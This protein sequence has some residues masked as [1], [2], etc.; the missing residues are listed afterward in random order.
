MHNCIYVIQHYDSVMVLRFAI[1][2]TD[3]PVS[4]TVSNDNYLQFY[5]VALLKMD[6]WMDEAHI[7]SNF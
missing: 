5:H 4:V 3:P 1:L 2:V 7:F 6:G